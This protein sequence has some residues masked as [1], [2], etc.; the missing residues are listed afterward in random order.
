MSIQRRISYRRRY[1]TATGCFGDPTT[2]AARGLAGLMLLMGLIF[3]VPARLYAQTPTATGGAANTCNG[4]T[5]ISY[6][7]APAQNLQGTVDRV[8]LQ[9][10]AGPIDNGTTLSLTQIFFDLSCRHK[11]C[12]NNVNTPCNTDPD[13]G[14]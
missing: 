12:S 2:V 4:V 6:P 11:G 3:A 14:G 13:C 8:Q 7:N 10:G 5:F 9:I 1:H